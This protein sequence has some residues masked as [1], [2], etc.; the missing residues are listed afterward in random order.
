MSASLATAT[1]ATRVRRIAWHWILA[2]AFLSVTPAFGADYA[3][4]QPTAKRDK[5]FAF[6]ISSFDSVW[7]YEGAD[8]DTRVERVGINWQ[9]T[10]SPKFHG[11]VNLGWINVTEFS[12]PIVEGGTIPGYFVGIDLRGL[13]IAQP[14]F[15]LATR[16]S[17][18]YN[19]ALGG[20]DAALEELSW[21]DIE[22]AL[23]A[24]IILGEHVGLY[25]GGSLAALD[26]R[27]S[28]DTTIAFE[29]KESESAFV[30]LD[31]RVDRSGHIGFQVQTG[32]LEGGLLYFRRWF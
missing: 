23:T 24:Q 5:N 8:V 12:S 25:G 9:E 14:R 30:G 1:I 19:N 10:L 21:Y 6:E 11:G 27:R 22:V 3:F 17:A 13:L 7:N 15:Q 2:C 29:S 16:L 20:N 26:G 28:G 4:W 32:R 31:L 18:T